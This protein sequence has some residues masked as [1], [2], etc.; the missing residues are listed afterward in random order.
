MQRVLLVSLSHVFRSAAFL[1][2]PFSFIALVA[3]STAGSAS[4]ST[5]DPIRGAL[6][7]WLGAHHVPFQLSLP[8]TGVAG[9]LTYLPIG[10]VVLPF[11]IIRS[12]FTR[13]LDRLKGDYHDL[14]IVRLN[15]SII[16]ALLV[17]ILAFMSR[18]N[19]VAAQWYLAPLFAF[20]IALISTMTVGNRVVPSRPLRMSARVLSILLGVSF[21]LISVLIFANFS[22]VKNISTSLQPGIFGGVL[23]LFL[24][25]LYLPNAAIAVA[26]YFSGTGLAVGAG[27]V[28]SPYWYQLGQI[29]ALPLLG[30]L[31]VGPV[32]LA[33]LGILF[34]VGLGALLGYFTSN[35]DIRAIAQ[36]YLFTVVALVLL[37]YLASGSLI[38]GEMGSMGVS[39]WK[40]ALSV[41]FEMG[42]GLALTI[43]ITNK[44]LNRGA[45]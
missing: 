10:A 27:T 40:F 45:A 1:L 20:A 26:S 12:S 13:A 29:P 28:I 37:G 34:F 14:N 7:I 2:L 17:T 24:N 42:I 36:S 3:W 23:L 33:L 19:S 32:P 5:T 30:I 16:Y 4:G 8:P 22:Q 9:Y 44:V 35:F 15:F 39:I 25:I 31:P 21:I 38:T 18:S 43:L 6:W 41:A 11:L